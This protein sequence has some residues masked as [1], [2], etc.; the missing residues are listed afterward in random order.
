MEFQDRN[1][2]REDIWSIHISGK[3][4]PPPGA[5]MQAEV[6]AKEISKQDQAF[7]YFFLITVILSLKKND[8]IDKLI[9]H[10]VK[11]KFTHTINTPSLTGF[12][13]FFFLFISWYV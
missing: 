12:H 9:E 11:E 8:V 10:Q 1:V 7:Y 3:A 6:C 4:E 2:P 13:L 5:Q